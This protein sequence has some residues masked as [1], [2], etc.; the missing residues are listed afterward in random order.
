MIRSK[1]MTGKKATEESRDWKLNS[2]EALAR[3]V[4][5]F[6]SWQRIVAPLCPQ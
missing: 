6:E 4:D 1:V 2:L 5:S 3:K